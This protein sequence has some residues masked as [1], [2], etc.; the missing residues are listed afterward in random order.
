MTDKLYQSWGVWDACLNESKLTPC[1]H[2]AKAIAG[3]V[4][5][6]Y[7]DGERQKNC[8]TTDLVNVMHENWTTKILMLDHDND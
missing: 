2:Q 1:N 5:G 6:N 4:V 8:G 3:R 7:N